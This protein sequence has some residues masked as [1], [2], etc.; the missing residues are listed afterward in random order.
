MMEEEKE[1]KRTP[2]VKVPVTLLS[3]ALKSAI[4]IS[5]TP[6]MHAYDLNRDCVLPSAIREEVAE[7]DQDFEERRMS[8]PTK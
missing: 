8:P 6:E 5:Q 3:K 1:G 2:K 4:G 7:E